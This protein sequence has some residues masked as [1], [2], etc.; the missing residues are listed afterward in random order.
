MAVER[1][2]EIHTILVAPKT[3]QFEDLVAEEPTEVI[4]DE[5]LT[6]ELNICQAAYHAPQFYDDEGF[7]I[8]HTANSHDHLTPKRI[9]KLQGWHS[10][11]FKAPN[12]LISVNHAC[13]SLKDSSTKA[14]IE[15]LNR[16]IRSEKI[17]TLDDYRRFRKK[18]DLIYITGRNGNGNHK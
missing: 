17:I 7:V 14:R 8:P 2:A 4:D 11:D 16:I 6:K 9:A 10:N 12:E 15:L 1:T 18:Y 13:H 3:S 5:T